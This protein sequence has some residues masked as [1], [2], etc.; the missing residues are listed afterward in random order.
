M[1]K[2]YFFAG[3]YMHT[4][5]ESFASCY[6]SGSQ[7][8]IWGPFYINLPW[9]L[10]SLMTFPEHYKIP[11]IPRFSMTKETL[12]QRWPFFF[13]CS[14]NLNINTTRKTRTHPNLF[15]SQKLKQ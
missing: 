8:G 5:Y 12:E 14:W 4:L 13:L 1:H 3:R 7:Q 2:Y 6:S 10:A 9:L 15:L 11:N